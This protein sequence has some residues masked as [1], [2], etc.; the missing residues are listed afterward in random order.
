MNNLKFRMMKA[1]HIRYAIV[2]FLIFNFQFL[3]G[4]KAQAQQLPLY[5]SYVYNP[6]LLSPSF[7]GIMDTKN[8]TARLMLAHRFQ[9]AGFEGAPTTSLLA[10]DAPFSKQNMGLGGMLYTDVTG[11]IRRTGL[12]L[13]YRYTVNL[14][15]KIQWHLGLSGSAGQQALD[16]AAVRAV[17]MSENILNLQS[18]NKLFVNGAFGTHLTAGNLMFGFAV[19]QLTRN[20][21]VYQN[22][23]SNTNYDYTQ[24]AHFQ[25]FASYKIDIKGD[26]FGL[27]PM[28]S[29][30]YVAGTQ[31]QY[32]V[33]V[34]AHYRNKVFLT[35]GYRGGYALSF[36]AGAVLNNNLTL[37]YTYDY[38]IN[39]AGPY[40][41]GGNEFT[42][43]YRFMKGKGLPK[44]P[45]STVVEG[46]GNKLS[47]AEVDAI[48][49]EKVTAMRNKMEELAR[50]N[51]AQKH[52]IEG[53]NNKI[54]SLHSDMDK[55][56][57][58]AEKVVVVDGSVAN[59]LQFESGSAKLTNSSKEELNKIAAFLTVNKD[60]MLDISGHTDNTGNADA[61]LILSKKRAQAVFDYL[62]SLG[63]SPDRMSHQGYGDSK[64]L[65]DNGTEAGRI[66]NRRVELKIK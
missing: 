25:G 49:E 17:D 9:Y 50:E 58:D 12:S 66:A 46:N 15:D 8:Q 34:K 26:T 42:L 47:E 48:F 40:T 19:K 23:T 63:I 62:V 44:A 61:N 52:K 56:K 32:D 53:L 51:E 45:Q 24:P 20:Q 14:N 10:L 28:V 1:Q 57:E 35:A 11:L 59:D 5:S 33:I 21:L 27:T 37:S 30:R 65:A 18:A 41:G 7:A 13:N 54:D 4:N 43:G 55:I 36:G 3:I 60:M 38:M 6:M 64:P 16:M 29:A 31:L 2:G 22:Y 39:A